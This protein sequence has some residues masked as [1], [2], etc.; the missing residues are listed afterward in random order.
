LVEL[1][2]RMAP[3]PRLA[4]YVRIGVGVAAMNTSV[5]QIRLFAEVLSSFPPEHRRDVLAGVMWILGFS[6]SYL[7][8][9]W[10]QDYKNLTPDQEQLLRTLEAQA[11]HL[12][13]DG[14]LITTLPAVQAFLDHL[15][16]LSAPHV[17]RVLTTF[18]GN[19]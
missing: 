14:D 4:P 19:P 18:R 13:R 17:D 8:P 7:G 16:E 2:G 6:A 9:V 15:R 3:A 12:L 1:A 11:V 10:L 5:Q